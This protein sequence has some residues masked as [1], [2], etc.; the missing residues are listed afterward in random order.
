[1][2]IMLTILLCI[3]ICDLCWLIPYLRQMC[4]YINKVQVSNTY[5]DEMQNVIT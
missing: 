2:P 5:K 1:M 3:A 4:Q